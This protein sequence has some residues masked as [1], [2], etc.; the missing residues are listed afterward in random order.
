MDIQHLLETI[1][2]TDLPSKITKH[3]IKEQR[4]GFVSAIAYVIGKVLSIVFNYVLIPLVQLMFQLPDFYA[5]VDKKNFRGE[6]LDANDT[7]LLDQNDPTV[8]VKEKKLKTKFGFI[9]WPEY[10][11]PD[12]DG[13]GYFWKFIKFCIKISIGIVIGL[14]GGIYLLL[15]GMIF[16]VAKI[17]RDFANRPRAVSEKIEK[18]SK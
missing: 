10:T 1:L 9:P 2:K 17:F 5:D 12:L 4:G 15:G 11:S 14:L 16:M 6:F 3:G 7:V 8:R 13:T 18:A